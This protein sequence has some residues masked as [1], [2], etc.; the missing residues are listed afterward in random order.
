MR[1]H[2]GIPEHHLEFPRNNEL[3]IPPPLPE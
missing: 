2:S 3:I 1:S